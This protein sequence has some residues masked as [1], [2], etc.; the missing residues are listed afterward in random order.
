MLFWLEGWGVGHSLEALPDCYLLG[1]L[2]S[3]NLPCSL[4]CS[5]WILQNLEKS[6]LQTSQP[7]WSALNQ[8]SHLLAPRSWQGAFWPDGQAMRETVS[9]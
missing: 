2:R 4:L 5:S 6:R 8:G 1:F 3:Q 7:C 9:P